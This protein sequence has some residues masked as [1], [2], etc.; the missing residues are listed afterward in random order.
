MSIS[1]PDIDP[2]KITSLEEAK[3]A[4]HLLMNSFERLIHL[5]VKVEEEN[6]SLKEE[7]AELKGQPKKPHF[8][9]KK[10]EHTTSSIRKLLKQKGVWH[11]T[12]KKGDLPVDE[13]KPIGEI[14]E[15]ECGSQEFRVLRTKAKIV[16]G[17][18]IQRHN[19]LYKG[20]DKECMKCGKKYKT[21]L[22]KESFNATLK[23]L[24]SFFKFCC[25]MTYPLMYRMLSGFG[26]QISNGEINEIL[27][28][29]SN[30]LNLSYQELRTTGFSQSSYLQSDATGAKR[31]EKHTGNMRNQY[32]QIIGNKL[33]SVFSITKYYNSKTLNR[34]LGIKGRSKPFVSDDGSPNGECLKNK[35]KQLCWVHEI[36]HYKKLFPFFTIYHP[37]EN[38]ILS[39]WQMFYHGAKQYGEA[40]PE[41]RPHLRQEIE[42]M[43]DTITS[44]TTEYDDLNKQLRLTRKKKDRLLTFLT[45]PFLPIHNNQCEQD[46]REY[47]IQ[48]KISGGTKSSAGDRSIERH[49]SVIQTAQKQGLDVF[50][51]LHGLLTGTLSPKILTATIS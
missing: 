7:I 27:Q 18:I 45:Y 31:Q 34:L 12:S 3:K 5:Y 39:Q 50:Q 25:R 44:Q 47:V 13:E 42:Q 9:S 23:S 35:H 37:L 20:R 33:L 19:V 22:P 51:T 24:L 49:L 17:M 43:F 46:L 38:Q 41:K 48:R 16:Q 32:A 1:L 21:T 6:Q 8:S 2:A 28:G 14:E 4:M 36:R 30:N 11:K 40:P 26:V 15:C 10:K 29:N